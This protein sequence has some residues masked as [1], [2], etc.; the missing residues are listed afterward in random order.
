MQ[1]WALQRVMIKEGYDPI[2]IDYLP[3][4]SWIR[5][6]LS[7]IRFSLLKIAGKKSKM[8]IREG[9]RTAEF[10]RFIS[11]NINKTKLCHSYNARIVTDYDIDIVCIGSDQVWRPSYNG[12]TLYD[13]YGRFSYP[14]PTFAYAASFGGDSWEY[15][16]F[17]TMRC[18]KLVKKLKGVSV[19]EKSAIN[20]C[21]DYLKSKATFV[22]DPTL[23]IDHEEYDLL[24]QSIPVSKGDYVLA[25]ILDNNDEKQSII[26]QISNKLNLELHHI[27][28]YDKK[29]YSVEEWLREFRDARYVITDSFHGLV[30]SII[31]KKN[32]KLL[33]NRH[34]GTSRFKSL[35]E[36]C[37]LEYKLQED[38]DIT[39]IDWRRVEENINRYREE[40]YNYL[41]L[42]LK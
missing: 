28:I 20:I 9:K 42:M 31:F 3:R 18:Q 22:L 27:S 30:F 29:N 38:K 5:H 2:T 16:K 12:Y 24:I 4:Q 26:T 21:R 37:G 40:S 7:L 25:Y 34:R 41:R 13:M 15:N 10:E 36:T 14:T 6:I 11:Q 32:F 39:Q 23:L 33:S 8:P 35:L 1:N 17:Q 19:R